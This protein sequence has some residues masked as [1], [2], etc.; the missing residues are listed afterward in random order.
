MPVAARRRPE[1]S[2]FNKSFPQS[3]ND[4]HGNNDP[5]NH[6]LKPAIHLSL[7]PAFLDS[8]FRWNDDGGIDASR[9]S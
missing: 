5:T 7:G 2:G 4:N 1:S 6:P 8:S 9:Y 3:E